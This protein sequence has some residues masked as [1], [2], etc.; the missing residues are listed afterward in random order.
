M[1]DKK[2]SGSNWGRKITNALWIM[3]IGGVLS[4]VVFFF[5]LSKQDLPTFDDLE[6]PKIELATRVLTHD[7]QELDRLFIHNRVQTKFEDLNPYLVDALISTEDERYYQHAGID[8]QALG[9][10]LFKSIIMGNS[11][12]GGGS[13]ITQQLSK[14]L[15]PRNDFSGMNKLQ[16]MWTLAISK[17]KE[18]IT[19]TKLEKS[20]TKEEIIAMYLNKFE[21]I[22]DSYG[23]NAAAETYFGKNQKELDQDEAAVL[24]G[25]LKNPV[26]YNPMKFPENSLSRRNVVLKQMLKAGKMQLETYDSLRTKPI[27]MSNF[28]RKH[29]SDGVAPYLM[30]EIKNRA[31]DILGQERYFKDKNT[32]YDIYKDGLEILTTIDPVVQ[33]LAYEAVLEHMPKLQ[34]GYDGHWKGMNPMTYKAEKE[35]IEIRETMLNNLIRQT[36]RYKNTRY[37]QIG[38][39]IQKV[40]DEVAHLV[41]TDTE[42]N[43]LIDEEKKAG[44]IAGLQARGTINKTKAK[45]MRKI[46]ESSQWLELRTKYEELQNSLDEEFNQKVKMKVFDYGSPGME[47]IVEMTPMDSIIYHMQFLQTGVLVM[48]SKEGYIKGWVGG[49]NHQYFKYD[50]VTSHRQVGSTFKPFVYATAISNNISPCTEVIDQAYTISPGENGFYLEEPWTP[51]NSKNFSGEKMNLKNGL[52]KS[53]NSFSV[54]LMKQFGSVEPVLELAIRMGLPKDQIPPVP[55]IALG[56]AELSVEELTGAYATFANNGE[57]NKPYVILSIKDKNGKLIYE[58]KQFKQKAL[59]STTN[60]AMID[61]LKYS[62]GGGAVG[63]ESEVGGKTGTTNDHVDGWFMGITPQ[64]TMGVWVGGDYPWIRFR[65]LDAGQGAVMARPIFRYFMQNLEKQP[66][67]VYDPSGTFYKPPGDLG[68]TI[69]CAEW[70]QEP[71]VEE[72]DFFNLEEE[73]EA[74]DVIQQF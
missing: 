59:P 54:W 43:W 5:I 3:A 4:V 49:I 28:K 31:Q 7:R 15:Y 39:S 71:M 9:R 6:N 68:I 73:E 53:L 25:M 64:I 29:S 35:Q 47:K 40:Q 11:S 58:H 19:A 56:V 22:Y 62:V 44:R 30:Q 74:F 60:Y 10:V 67:E 51:S 42:I 36:D 48:D 41:M 34:S 27:D 61:M 2:S 1:S 17:F 63:L 38:K 33:K 8:M 69:D 12:Y 70:I 24:V 66:K 55:S 65:T 57:Y 14:L 45:S 72:A 46:L 52:K 13:T 20:Y 37:K 16:R 23:I 18:W 26:Y 32:P 21:F 50:H